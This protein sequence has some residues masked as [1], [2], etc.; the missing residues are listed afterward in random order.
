MAPPF[1]VFRSKMFLKRWFVYV[2]WALPGDKQPALHRFTLVKVPPQIPRLWASLLNGE[3]MSLAPLSFRMVLI[4]SV[5]CCDL[6]PLFVTEW[7]PS[8]QRWQDCEWWPILLCWHIHGRWA[9]QVSMIQCYACIYAS[10]THTPTYTHMHTP[11]HC[12]PKL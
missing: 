2:E 4:L 5:I 3:N 8:D 7:S 1:F 6:V 9:D 10:P 12:V 11:R